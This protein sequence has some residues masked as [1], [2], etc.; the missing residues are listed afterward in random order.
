MKA[1]LKSQGTK[2]LP[3]ILVGGVLVTQGEYPVREVLAGFAAVS[4]EPEPTI[5]RV[6]GQSP[7]LVSIGGPSTIG[8]G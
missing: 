3:L 5:T 6:K 4:Y 2:C 7:P 8:R 1:T